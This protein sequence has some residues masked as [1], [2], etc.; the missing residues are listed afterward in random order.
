MLALSALTLLS[1]CSDNPHVS[2]RAKAT[3]DGVQVEVSLDDLE[4][5]RFAGVTAHDGETLTLPFSAFELGV[6]KLP[7]EG[8]GLDGKVVYFELE[9]NHLVSLS[10]T[11]EEGESVKLEPPEGHERGPIAVNCPV[12]GAVVSAQ[13]ETPEGVSLEVDDAA[14]EGDTLRVDLRPQIWAKDASE[15]KGALRLDGTRPARVSWGDKSWET[16]LSVS[17]RGRDML[18]SFVDALPESAQGMPEPG[19]LVAAKLGSFWAFGGEGKLG[20]LRLV[21]K[22]VARGEPQGEKKCRFREEMGLGKSTVVTVSFAPVTY[23]AFDRA[24]EEVARKE[25]RAS[26]CPDVVKP[27]KSKIVAVPSANAVKPW[28]GELSST[29]ESG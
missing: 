10:C 28:L 21:V 13:L 4:E 23:A 17:T 25:F 8:K 29:L 18:R 6:N 12:K 24:G 5:V 27:G 19:N 15:V 20:E 2:T 1:A 7:I 26:E 3:A 16:T 9:P 14:I 11:G 22:K